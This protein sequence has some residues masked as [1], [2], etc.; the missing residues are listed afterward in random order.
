M[1]DRS[2]RIGRAVRGLGILAAASTAVLA[3]SVVP[4]SADT[5]PQQA[6]GTTQPGPCTE[7]DHFTQQLGFVTPIGQPTKPS[8]CPDW[9]LND[10]P[11][12]D[13]T[14]NGIEHVTLNKAQDFWATSTFTGKGTITLYPASSLANLVI[15]DQGNVSADIVGPPDGVVT[16]KLQTWF[17]VSDNK[18]AGVVHDT[19]NVQV[20]GSGVTLSMHQNSHTSWSG[21][22]EPF[23]DMPHLS[24]AKISASC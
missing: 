20:S 9:V 3:L 2:R 4:A 12:L 23:V 8:A 15:D 24:F 16:G 1:T 17:G 6:C 18:Q 13:F 14:G 10:F 11:F 5:A 19:I 22:S 21:G 7:T